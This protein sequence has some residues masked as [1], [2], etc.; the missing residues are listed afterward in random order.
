MVRD[1]NREFPLEMAGDVSHVGILGESDEILVYLESFS[2]LWQD[3]PLVDD[4]DVKRRRIKTH[5]REVRGEG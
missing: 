2:I 5:G 3:G 1:L 4:I